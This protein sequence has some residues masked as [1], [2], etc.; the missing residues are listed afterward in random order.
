MFKKIS[1]TLLYLLIFLFPIFFLPISA[2]SLFYPKEIVFIFLVF[3]SLFFWFLEGIFSKNKIVLRENNFFYLALFFLFF[4]SG[5]SSLFSISKNAS[6]WGFPLEIGESF[7]FLLFCLLFVFLILNVFENFSEFFTAFLIFFFSTLILAFLSILQIYNIYSF[8][9]LAGSISALSIFFAF[10]LPIFL[11][12]YF[13]SKGFGKIVFGFSLLIFLFLLISLGVKFSFVLIFLSAIF[14]LIFS[15]EKK[16]GVIDLEKGVILSVFLIISIFYFFFPLRFKIFPAL[17][18]EVSL[19]FLA[20]IPILKGV[21]SEGIKNILLGTGPGTFIFDY[22]KYRPVTLNQTLFWG[23]RFSFG[24]STIF[25]W[26][27]TKGLFSTFSLVF[28]FLVSFFFI[29]KKILKEREN[30]K[31][32]EIGIFTSTLLTFVSLFFFSFNLFL[33]FY[34]YFFLAGSFFLLS[35][36]KEIDFSLIPFSRSLFFVILFV[37]ISFSLILLG[38]QIQKYLANVYYKMAS[39]KIG[40]SLDL[41][42]ELFRKAAKLNSQADIY[43]R[44]LSQTLLLKATQISQNQKISEDEKRNLIN[45]LVSEGISAIDRATVLSPQNVANWNVK[46]FFF[47]NL[48][49]VEG[50]GE[51]AIQSYQNAISLEPSSPY[52]WTETGRVYILMAQKFV[53]KKTSYLNLAKNNLEKAIELKSDYAPAHYLMA[54]AFSQEGKEKEAISKLEETI[55]IAPN[56]LGLIYQLS[57]LYYRTDETEKAENLLK[58]ALQSFPQYSNA[59]YLLGLVY[60]KKGQREKAL[61]EFKKVAELNP[62]NEEV[63]RIL[64]NLEKGLP[65]LEGILTP[66]T[67]SEEKPT[68]IH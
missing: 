65:A 60:D 31:I 38:W 13:Q 26:L 68:E 54:V 55:K 52:S 59:R 53:D 20:E 67:L 34:F 2:D 42:I 6:F 5:L 43:W 35:K 22:S 17:P 50:A 4:F 44:D 16:K 24:A 40:E 33:W 41:A 51:I 58:S 11:S 39:Q 1:K 36:E 29:I 49:G 32:L 21:F 10:S 9:N 19:D 7:L 23:T 14:L 66:K 62:E 57:L 25:D 37:T 46:G 61:E 30:L 63:K 8:V 56:D 18:V 3:L 12:L 45:R 48:I 15:L 27:I 28:L 47:R 64:E